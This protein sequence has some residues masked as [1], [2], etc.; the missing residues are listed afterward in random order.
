MTTKLLLLL[1]PLAACASQV[2][3]NNQGEVIATMHGALTSTRMSPLPSPEVELVWLKPSEMSAIV[4][5]EHVD[6]KGLVSQFTLDIYSPPPDNILEV[7]PELE[8]RPIG[9][10]LVVVGSAGSDF[11]DMTKWRGADLDHMLIY[12]PEAPAPDGVL[13]AFVHATG[14]TTAGFHL[15]TVKR[16][17]DAERQQRLDCVNAM[18]ISGMNLDWT[19]IF[20]Q[21]G[22]AGNDELYPAP[23]DMDTELDAS[24]IE[25]GAIVQ[26]INGIP[27][28]LGI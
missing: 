22:G 3:G 26:L 13:S 25:D 21:C 9:M 14:A 5:A 15:Y 23:Q 12:F 10:G 6:A 4:G 7:Q 19:A 27:H 18:P 16:L 24:V 28:P 11:T 20:R 8:S 2:D 1:V 17:T